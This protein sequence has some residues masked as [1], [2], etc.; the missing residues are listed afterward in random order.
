M[1]SFSTALTAI[2]D[3]NVSWLVSQTDVL[4][5]DWIIL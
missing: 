3:G 4:A 2:K 5:E 1:L